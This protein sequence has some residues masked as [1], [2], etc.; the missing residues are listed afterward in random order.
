MPK[1]IS[2]Q[3]ALASCG[4]WLLAQVAAGATV[5]LKT[6]SATIAPSLSSESMLAQAP[7]SLPVP[8]RIPED[9]RRPGITPRPD[10]KPLP[11]ELP[12]PP[13]QPPLQT[14]APTPPVNPGVPETTVRIE[15]VEVLGSTVFSPAELAAVVKP[16]EQRDLTFEQLLEIRTAVT[17]LYG[18]RGY[19]T[20]GAFLPP[21]DNLASGT[22]RIQVIEGVLEGIE[23][24]GLRRL[25]ESYVR[26]RLRLAG[27]PPLNIR[28]LE[29]A[30]QLLQLDPLFTS[31]R[32]ELKAGTSPG[33]S[34]ISVAL[35]EAPTLDG[36]I[37]VE[38]RDSP[39]VGSERGTFVISDRNLLGFG[40]RLSL[41]YG[42]T[43]GIRSYDL[44]YEIPINARDG[45]LSLRY[46]RS[47]SEI[48]EA[49]FS[50]LDITSNSKTFAVA[51]RQPLNRTPTQEFALELGLDLRQSQTFLLKDIPFSFSLGPENGESKVTVLRFSQDWINRSPNRV[52]AARSQFS[53]G[54]NALGATVNDTG[55]DGRFFSWVGQF[56]WVQSFGD[57][58]SIAR[59]AAQLTPDSLLPL[60]Q[61]SL[62]GVDTVRG[63]RQNQRVAD[64]GVTGSLEI[65]VPIIRS[66]DKFGT[67]Q[68]APFLDLGRVWNS[69]E[70]P[71]ASP[72][73]LISTGIGLRWQF[74][75][76]FSARLDWGFPLISVDKQGETL[77]DNGIFFSIRLQP[78]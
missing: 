55:T 33:R 6:G 22:V 9:I 68:L 47:D 34:V 35:K 56:Q 8:P 43:E 71:I 65:R 46:N 18:D 50:V 44:S 26:N 75:P 41:E 25:K 28:S 16:F 59:V 37:L 62:G 78:F 51:L 45:V 57:I 53:L 5:P 21:Q 49:P 13:L 67:V 38:N 70:S 61:F 11:E 23:I 40:D 4:L 29:T 7:P 60:E 10:I 74:D 52:L 27:R 31:V 20:S 19:T 3:S 76:Y 39:S 1:P 12:T 30:L 54:L 24:E 77:Q 72:R 63:Y 17:K 64:N 15:K 48:V 73:T 2:L 69:S 58:I 32:A 66:P 14:P 42:L 36:V